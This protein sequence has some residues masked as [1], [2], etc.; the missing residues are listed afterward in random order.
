MMM[1]MLSL[2]SFFATKWIFLLNSL[3]V[4]ITTFSV[5][6]TS[7]D[8]YSPE[9]YDQAYRALIFYEFSLSALVVILFFML[10]NSNLSTKQEIKNFEEINNKNKRLYYLFDKIAKSSTFQEELRTNMQKTTLSLN[11]IANEQTDGMAKIE[12]T[13]IEI[14]NTIQKSAS[15]TKKMT[16][17]VNETLGYIKNSKASFDE[18]N[19]K[20]HSIYKK[21]DTISDIAKKTDLLAINAAIEAA[22]AGESGKGFS[23]VSSEI[24][25]LAET[26]QKSALNIIQTVK[27]STVLSDQTTKYFSNITDKTQ[28]TVLD[29]KKTEQDIFSQKE[30]VEQIR[31]IVTNVHENSQNNLIISKELNDLMKILATNTEEMDAIVKKNS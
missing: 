25:K 27:E 28:K 9:I 13:I 11:E 7:K 3:I 5:F 31:N 24:R 4:Y 20:I 10:T 15:N 17:E 6:I 23:V 29:I 26:S 2:G 19:K 12:S 30:S 21:T 1:M 22:R 8:L 14:L 16:L 18:V